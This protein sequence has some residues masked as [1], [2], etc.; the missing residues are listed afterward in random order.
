MF[1]ELLEPEC[2]DGIISVLDARLVD[3]DRLV[4]LAH[5]LVF[6]MRKVS[7]LFGDLRFVPRLERG[8]DMLDTV[9]NNKKSLVEIAQRA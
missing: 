6:E 5:D 4:R 9:D 2:A 1:A 3:D 8:D 7:V